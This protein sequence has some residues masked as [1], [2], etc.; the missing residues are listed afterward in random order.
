[1]DRAYRDTCIIWHNW[2]RRQLAGKLPQPASTSGIFKI[3]AGGPRIFFIKKSFT[4]DDCHPEW[5]SP[6]LK[7]SHRLAE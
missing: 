7:S 6:Y 2:E 3:Q 4:I 1:M 5:S